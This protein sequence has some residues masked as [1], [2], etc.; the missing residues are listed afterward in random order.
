MDYRRAFECMTR[1]TK[2]TCIFL[3]IVFEANIY[4][5]KKCQERL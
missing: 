4:D 5:G 2:M 3:Q 1:E